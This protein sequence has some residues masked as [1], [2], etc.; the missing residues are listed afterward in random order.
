MKYVTDGM[1]DA[2]I[3][4]VIRSNEKQQG[5]VIIDIRLRELSTVY[6]DG[7]GKFTWQNVVEHRGTTYKDAAKLLKDCMG[8]YIHQPSVKS[9][10]YT[11]TI[12][13]E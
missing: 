12:T 10:R 13:K 5:N 6:L 7:K 4:E 2:E 8:K 11:L 1:T 9:M 3:M